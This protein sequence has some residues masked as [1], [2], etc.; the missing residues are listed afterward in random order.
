MQPEADPNPLRQRTGG[1]LPPALCRPARDRRGFLP[2]YLRWPSLPAG[3]IEQLAH[4]LGLVNQV[5]RVQPE[6]FRFNPESFLVWLVAIAAWKF[7]FHDFHW[8]CT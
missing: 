6:T 7:G 3:V 4:V 2:H 5:Q 8:R 1:A